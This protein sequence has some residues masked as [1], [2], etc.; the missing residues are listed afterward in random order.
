MIADPFTQIID[1]LDH[2]Q[3]EMNGDRIFSRLFE[4]ELLL[5]RLASDEQHD[6]PVLGPDEVQG[7]DLIIIEA[8]VFKVLDDFIIVE[9][10]DSIVSEGHSI[11]NSL[12]KK[13]IL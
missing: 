13:L 4:R 1:V 6:H 7:L 2:F 5:F 11:F 3:D 8:V 10:L 12:H 9:F